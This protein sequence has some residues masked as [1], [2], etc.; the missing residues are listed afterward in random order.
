MTRVDADD[1]QRALTSWNRQVESW[2]VSRLIHTAPGACFATTVQML[3]RVITTG[4]R[5]S[6]WRTERR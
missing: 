4:D 2:P 6:R 1:R 5:I 3:S